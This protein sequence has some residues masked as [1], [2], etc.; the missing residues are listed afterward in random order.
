MASSSK[1][2]TPNNT[3]YIQ[4]DASSFKKVVQKLTGLGE[5]KK[6]PPTHKSS[7]AGKSN[8]GK[9]GPR[10]QPFKLQERRERARKLEIKL[11]NGCCTGGGGVGQRSIF[12]FGAEIIMVS[13][14]SPLE[15]L[16]RGSPRTPTTPSSSA[17][18]MEDEEKRGIYEKGYYLH[19]ESVTP[20]GF[21]PPTLLPLFPIASSS[22]DDHPASSPIS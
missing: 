4:T 17:P 9:M 3:T 19:P 20:T 16:T 10:R 7:P 12:G 22:R 18:L 2:S 6:L 14:V 21:K 1:T 8:S 11:N 5:E 15:L 13:P